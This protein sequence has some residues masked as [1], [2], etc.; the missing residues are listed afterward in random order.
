MNNQLV[1]EKEFGFVLRVELPI[2]K[3]SVWRRVVVPAKATFTQ[4]H[5]ILQVCFN[6]QNEHLHMFQILD[7]D[8]EVLAVVQNDVLED[9]YFDETDS[10]KRFTERKRLSWFMPHSRRIT[11]LYDFGDDWMHLIELEQTIEADHGTLPVCLNG[12]GDAPPED[13]GGEPG[14]VSF[15]KAINSTATG[16]RAVRRREEYLNWAES[17]GWTRFNLDAVNA[18]LLKLRQSK[19]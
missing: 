5:R 11:Y 7:D 8:G 14:F 6:W 4:L 9:D 1:S 19:K 16:E 13:V 18:R 12:D 2:G 17:L 15:L 3:R 10:V